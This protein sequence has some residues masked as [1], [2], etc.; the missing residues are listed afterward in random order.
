MFPMWP[1][2]PVPRL[3][4]AGATVLALVE[5]LRSIRIIW[6][7]TFRPP[8]FV[9]KMSPQKKFTISTHP[10]DAW[11][12]VHSLGRSLTHERV[13]LSGSRILMHQNK[14]NGFACVSCSWAKPAKPHPFEF[15]EEGAKA[16]TWEITSRRCTPEFFAEHTVRSLESWSDHALEEQG[17]LTH[18]LRYDAAS[19]KY[20]VV[21]WDQ[22]ISEI[23]GELKTLEPR[24][25]VFYSSGRASLEAS[26]MYA[27]FARLYG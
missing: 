24:R 17:R 16:T 21:T 20:A 3:R 4:D 13:P 19:D 11:G 10:A 15:C 23:A 12:S 1:S 6:L 9:P 14:P 25:A 8:F 18:P 26:Y 27:L 5:L 22:A 7:G 2:G